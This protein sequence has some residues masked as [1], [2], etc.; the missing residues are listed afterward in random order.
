MTRKIKGTTFEMVELIKSQRGGLRENSGRKAIED[1]K[2]QVQIGI[3][4][5]DIEKHGGLK[6][7][8]NKLL[9][10]FSEMSINS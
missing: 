7:V 3:S 10:S 8:Q 1:K 2:I 6:A 9:K 5:S 4:K